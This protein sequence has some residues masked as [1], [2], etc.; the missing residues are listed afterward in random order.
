[1]K[2]RRGGKKKPTPASLLAHKRWDAQTAEQRHDYAMM[3]VAARINKRLTKKAQNK[4]GPN[5][6]KEGK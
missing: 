6:P 2:K 1:M 5:G 3:M 4:N